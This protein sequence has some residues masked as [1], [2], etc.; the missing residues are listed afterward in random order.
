MTLRSNRS[1]PFSSQSGAAAVNILWPIVL[2][3]LLL[4]AIGASFLMADEATKMEQRAIVAETELVT[5]TDPTTGRIVLLNNELGAITEA[6]G[7]QADKT[8][9]RSYSNPDGAK[10]ALATIGDA[11]DSAGAGGLG[12]SVNPLEGAVPVVSV[13][14]SGLRTS[15]RTLQTRVADLES[16]LS[17]ALR[18]KSELVSTNDREK[19]DLRREISDAQENSARQA[20]QF[21]DQIAGLRRQNRELKDEIQSHKSAA[22]KTTADHVEEV[23]TFNNTIAALS[24]KLE[25]QKEP[26]NVDGEIL[27]VSEKL[28]LA[29]IDLGTPHRVRRGMKFDVYGSGPERPHKGRIEVTAVQE[30]FS[31]V[32][33]LAID[34]RFD[35]LV[36]G[37]L[38]VNA[39]FD[40]EQTLYAVLHDKSFFSGRYDRQSLAA[41][42]DTVGVV[43]QEGI[44]PETD[45]LILGFQDPDAEAKRAEETEQ[46][47]Q[48]QR[49]GVRIVAIK[50]VLS[51]F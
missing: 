41:M 19:G 33:V 11:L 20:S 40:P 1:A 50:E 30:R 38:I 37:D 35:P 34:D 21:E 27:S 12:A 45:L 51:F 7:F 4:V 3:V 17:Q 25:W 31:E 48:A 10:T 39:L 13:A 16:E 15:Q 46:F 28:P 9:V 22:T 36:S 14:L 6:M 8:D 32:R 42:L 29:Y 47:Q 24:R 49:R 23:R 26:D 5:Y 2:L 18:D 44:T 43:V